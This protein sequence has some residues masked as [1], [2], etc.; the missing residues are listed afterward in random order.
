M[1]DREIGPRDTGPGRSVYLLEDHEVVRRGLRR[2]LESKGFTIVG[3]SGSAREAA[4][5]IP[6]NPDLAILDDDLPDGS[7]AGVCRDVVAADPS[8]R[9]LVLTGEAAEGVLIDAILAGAWGCLSKQDNN[10]EQLRLISRALAGH[11]AFSRRFQDIRDRDEILVPAG[12]GATA[13][14]DA[15]DVGAVAAAALLHPSAHRNTAWT[16]TGKETLTYE[17]VARILTI[18]LGRPIRYAQPGIVRYLRHARQTLGMP[19]A[20]SSSR[21]PSTPPPGSDWRVA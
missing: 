10:S 21:P 13:F 19:W 1:T 8:I 17:Q 7:G 4:R 12:H 3:E 6:A 15:E 20:W 11:T 18:E 14:V 9:C 5:R 2:L 16:V